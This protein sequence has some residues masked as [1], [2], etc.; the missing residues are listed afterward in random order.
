MLLFCWSTIVT[1][2]WRWRFPFSFALRK[3][4]KTVSVKSWEWCCD[5]QSG[6]S[7]VCTHEAGSYGKPSLSSGPR[8]DCYQRELAQNKTCHAGSTKPTDFLSW[9]QALMYL[10]RY[11]RI[12]LYLTV[13]QLFTTKYLP[14]TETKAGQALHLKCGCISCITWPNFYSNAMEN[15]KL[16]TQWPTDGL[17]DS[18]THVLTASPVP[19]KLDCVKHHLCV[20]RDELMRS[21]TA[22]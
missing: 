4:P 15:F 11:I 1:G 19:K 22:M 10:Q 2:V 6:F 16:R 7:L 13:N 9:Y 12:S 5:K 8:K 18:Y 3:I 20:K 21:V 17:Q 14:C